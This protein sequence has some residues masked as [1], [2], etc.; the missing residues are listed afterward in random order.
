[1]AHLDYEEIFM[2]MEKS[3][4]NRLEQE[5]SLP[6]VQDLKLFLQQESDEGKI[7]YPPKEEVFQAF[8][9]TPF[10]KVKVVI[11]GQDPYH[12]KGQA[13]GLSFSVK[14]TV[15]VLPPSLKNIFKELCEDVKVP[16]P[17]NGCLSPWAKQGVFLLNATLTV[18][19]GEPKSHFGKGW[20]RFT[21]SVI[22]ALADQ[23][24]PLVFMLWG[25]S[26]QD[27]VEK[28][29]AKEKGHI[30]LTA[31]HPSPYS[32]ERFFGCRHFSKANEFLIKTGQSPINW[33]LS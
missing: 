14:E 6:Y 11:V 20:E 1:M 27:K 10:E 24:R 2:K 9:E 31:A 17:K 23:K 7:V 13:H 30:V 25:K 22:Q 12:G 19:E 16:S 3:W 18:R 28:I 4:R 8:L 32:A 21:D 5:I 26:A 15:R 33:S 29:H